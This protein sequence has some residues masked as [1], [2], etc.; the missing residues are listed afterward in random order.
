MC[1]TNFRH[2]FPLEKMFLKGMLSNSQQLS[3]LLLKSSTDIGYTSSLYSWPDL[4]NIKQKISYFIVQYS[5]ITEMLTLLFCEASIPR[6]IM[7][8]I[9]KAPSTQEGVCHWHWTKAS[10][11][12][13]RMDDKTL[14]FV[15]TSAMDNI[16][17]CQ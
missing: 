12:R 15:C 2:R 16:C 9:S 8:Y 17:P 7:C 11:R 3:Y 6:L 10:Y 14:A 4:G 5:D 13:H 1:L